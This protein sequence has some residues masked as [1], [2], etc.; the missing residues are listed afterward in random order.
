M[1]IDLTVNPRTPENWEGIIITGKMTI[2]VWQL[3]TNNLC[4]QQS[5][6]VK[7]SSSF[8]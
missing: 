6:V 4:S 1:P 3:K 7:V 2:I 8:K 5:P